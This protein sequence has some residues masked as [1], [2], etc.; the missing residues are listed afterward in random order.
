[1][2]DDGGFEE[3]FSVR[4][5]R[6]AL[7]AVTGAIVVLI[8][9]LV[10]VNRGPSRQRVNVASSAESST[11]ERTSTSASTATS[12]ATSTSTTE[13]LET[14]STLDQPI[15][16]DLGLSVQIVPDKPVFDLTEPITYRI[17]IHADEGVTLN[18]GVPLNYRGERTADPREGCRAD[19]SPANPSPLDIDAPVDAG[20]A[21][22]PGRQHLYSTVTVASCRDGQPV[23]QEQFVDATVGAIPLHNGP[24]QPRFLE[25]DWYAGFSYVDPVTQVP[26]HGP[27]HLEIGSRDIDGFASDFL[28]DWGDGTAPQPFSQYEFVRDTA[29][30]RSTA[31][32]DVLDQQVSPGDEMPDTPSGSYYGYDPTTTFMAATSPQHEYTAAGTYTITVTA[33]STNCDGGEPQSVTVSL[34]GTVTPESLPPDS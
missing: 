5:R 12:I 27:A 28:V 23:T 9:V 19:G 34:T 10:F 17:H 7:F 14:T 18:T 11:S 32:H 15:E 4:R 33:H 21:H 3:A 2:R 26:I 6:S 30:C 16:A 20:V 1:M 8:G 31:D 29:F 22:V 24:A 13:A 25:A